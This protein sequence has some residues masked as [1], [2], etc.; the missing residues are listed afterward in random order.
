MMDLIRIGLRAGEFH[1]C[2][3]KEQL[4][5][6][7]KRQRRN[8]DHASTKGKTVISEIPYIALAKKKGFDSFVGNTP[9]FTE[10]HFGFLCQSM[11]SYQSMRIAALTTSFFL[12]MESV[13]A[14]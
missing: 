11:Y 14:A 3:R 6:L 2:L 7:T 13:N 8:A 1:S 12:E 9:D 5:D 10:L 4:T